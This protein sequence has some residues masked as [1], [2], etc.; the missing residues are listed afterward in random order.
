[1]TEQVNVSSN[2]SATQNQNV[3]SAP[4]GQAPV[5]AA[6]QKVYTD[7][8]VNRIVGEKKQKA[9]EQGKQEALAELQ[10]QQNINS[11]ATQAQSNVNQQAGLTPEQEQRLVE[12]AYQRIQNDQLVHQFALKLQTGQ[13]KYSDF[14]KVV[15]PLQLQTISP[16]A[17]L[18][19]MFD[20]TADIIYDLGKN[21]AKVSNLMVLATINPNLAAQEMQRLS[22]SIKEN[23]QALANQQQVREP[24]SQPKS[25]NVGVD[26]GPRTIA[27]MRRDPR[28]RV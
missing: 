22:E 24:L 23:Q 10:K 26:G 25:S 18:A 11:T 9:Y 2:E 14:E 5:S 16:V 4:P 15:T 7:D 3:A 19:N 21:P 13:Q 8:D 17:R 12:Q 1:M 20:N 28:N 6:T 27:E